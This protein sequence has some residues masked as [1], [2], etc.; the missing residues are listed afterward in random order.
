[1]KRQ[2]KVVEGLQRLRRL[3]PVSSNKEVPGHIKGQ[4]ENPVPEVEQAAD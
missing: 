1:M 2:V 4:R 3:D